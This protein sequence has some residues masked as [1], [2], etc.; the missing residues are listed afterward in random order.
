MSVGLHALVL[1]VIG[2]RSIDLGHPPPPMDRVVYVEIEPRPLL[3]GEVAR[4]R[5]PPARPQTP[6]EALPD[7][8]PAT[9][10]SD[11]FRRPEDEDDRTAPS[12][13][14]P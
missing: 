8:G 14:P 1:G 7:A 5:P 11:P 3:P 13:P 2:L 6:A 4:V 9:A 10:R 12:P